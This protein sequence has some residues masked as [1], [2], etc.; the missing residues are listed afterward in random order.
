MKYREIDL[1][2]NFQYILLQ[3]LSLLVFGP[4]IIIGGIQVFNWITTQ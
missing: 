2:Q 3:I 1:P 4:L